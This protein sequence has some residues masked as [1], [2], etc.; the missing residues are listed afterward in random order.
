MGSV[1]RQ[2]LTLTLPSRSAGGAGEPVCERDARHRSVIE[3]KLSLPH[4][5][6]VAGQ[7]DHALDV[8]DRGV[9]W[10]AKHDYVTVLGLGRKDT[11]RDPGRCER[12]G[13][14][15]VAIGV[16][17]GEDVV[18]DDQRRGHRA[19]RNVERLIQEEAKQERRRP[20]HRDQQDQDDDRF[21]F[22]RPGR[23]ADRL[24]KSGHSLAMIEIVVVT[25]RLRNLR[26]RAIPTHGFGR[27][28][29]RT[30]SSQASTMEM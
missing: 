14:A 20:Q 9:L 5:D 19:G 2:R 17:G 21:P 12:K 11:A 3:D 13:I 7:P 28:G 27:T 6:A 8:V 29:A 24:L 22:P 1:S 30:R 18:A 23:R 10:R 15:A 25:V 16:F 26:A 4:L